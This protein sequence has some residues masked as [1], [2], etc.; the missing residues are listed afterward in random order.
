MI[1]VVVG[2]MS[3]SGSEGGTCKWRRRE[4]KVKGVVVVFAWISV[5]DAQIDEF[6]DLY[7]SLQWSSL[8]CRSDYLNP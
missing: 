3:S 5:S 2:E 6:V 1:C 7:D 8:V 4:G